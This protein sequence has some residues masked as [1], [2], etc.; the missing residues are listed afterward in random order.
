MRN[1]GSCNDGIVATTAALLFS[2]PTATYVNGVKTILSWKSLS[3]R[4][5]AAIVILTVFSCGIFL[6]VVLIYYFVSR[7][8]PKSHLAMLRPSAVK[9]RANN[10]IEQLESPIGL[11]RPNQF[12]QSAS[13]QPL[14]P[15]STQPTQPA[16]AAAPVQPPQ[17]VQPDTFRI[18]S[19]YFVGDESAAGKFINSLEEVELPNGQIEGT[20]A[21]NWAYYFTCNNTQPGAGIVMRPSR[22]AILAGAKYFLGIIASGN[23]NSDARMRLCV[24]SFLFSKVG[25]EHYSIFGSQV[26]NSAHTQ[27]EITS[28]IV[29]VLNS[30]F[31]S[32]IPAA[33]TGEYL[34]CANKLAELRSTDPGKLVDMIK[35]CDGLKVRFDAIN[36]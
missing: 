33:Y 6:L 28:A 21:D 19:R 13:A 26:F 24:L 25:V 22:D 16:A 7:N 30:L 23:G 20:D 29:D 12:G 14:Q 27:D 5:K 3:I 1:V 18:Y 4:Q 2:V 32:E 10:E 35:R 8:N 11:A 34:A 31:L 36:A 9:H 17:V 15:G